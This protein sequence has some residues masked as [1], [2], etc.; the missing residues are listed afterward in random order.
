MKKGSGFFFYVL[1]NKLAI[2]FIVAILAIIGYALIPSIPKGVFPNVFFPRIEV[3]IDDGYTPIRQML[4]A[5]TKPAEDTLKTVQ[6]VTKV[7]S[8]TSV[9]SS[10][11][12]LYFNWN[13]NPYLAYQLVQARIAALKNRLPHGAKIS[14]MQATPSKYPVAI[15]AIGSNTL[16]RTQLTKMLYYDL[17]PL[18]LSVKGVYD[19]Q[20]KAP[21]WSE[22]E[23]LLNAQ[24]MRSYHLN[25]QTLLR[26]LKAQNAIAF[27][28]LVND[29]HKQYLLSLYQKHT[30]ASSLLNLQIPLTGS[31]SVA[32]GDLAVLVK[33]SAPSREFSAA[34]GFRNAVVFNLLRQP[35]ADALQVVERFN[36]KIK[37]LAP[38]LHKEGITLASYYDG[39][40]FTKEA[41]KSVRDAVI[42]G[43]LIAVGV[44][45]FFL[46]KT[47][48]SL[49][50]LVLIPLTFAITVIGMKLFG[51]D[52]N[53]F[54]LGG[55]AAALGGLID[56]MI[57]VIENIER[58]FQKGIS[59]HDAVVEGSKEIL[60]I[61]GIATLLATLIFIPLLLV[62]GIVGL[63]FK[64]LAFVLV[65]TYIISQIIAI[66]LT[67]II[68]FAALP[69]P[70]KKEDFLQPLI[71]RYKAFLHRAFGFAW[72][73]LPLL[74]LF[75]LLS[76]Y[77]FKS[78]PSTFLPKWDEGNI[79]MDFTL[80]PGISVA[81]SKREFL[82]AAA[83][84]NK[85]K[86][87]KDWT[88]RLGTSLGAVSNPA[89]IGDFL[90]TLKKERSESTFVVMHRLRSEILQAVPNLQDLG[91]SQ[92]LEDRLGDIMGAD[93]PIA[94]RLFGTH[95]IQLIQEGNKLKKKL[96]TLQGIEE[97]NVLTSYASPTI[98]IRLKND[99]EALYGIDTQMLATQIKTLYYGKLIGSIAKG[100]QLIDVR[101]LLSRP[102]ED[103]L[104]YLQD[105]LL[106]YSAKLHKNIPLHDVA[107]IRF[108]N[109]VPQITHYNLSP[110]C[111]LGVHFRGNDMS[112][113]VQEIR[114]TLQQASLPAGITA[115]IGGIYKQQQRSFKQMGFVILFALFILFTGLLLR[116][117]SFE[118]PF[119]IIIALIV[120]L[121]G[122][123]LA[124]KLTAKPLDIT[125]FM[126]MLI[127]LSI[128]I[129]NNV[130]IYDFYTKTADEDEKERIL[131]AVGMRIR[132]VLMTMLSNAFALLP[133]ALAIGSGTQIIQD[134]AIAVM[135]GLIFAIFINLF[136]TP[137][138]FYWLKTLHRQKN[139]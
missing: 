86:A 15:Y 3:T 89:N 21:R 81:Q 57:I 5:V 75:F 71:E 2:F 133:I 130:L 51:I 1:K 23:I 52:F 29:Y 10:T 20:I 108:E 79:V 118:I 132:P 129:N 54:S 53:I 6:D 40:R 58:H 73:S 117:S 90:V 131:S 59:K 48:L 101:V 41:I 93:A 27:A 94:V 8:S 13:I 109:R 122:V 49:A 110:V 84:L 72:I 69:T 120:T 7:V 25:I 125:A 112:M 77:L 61:M 139:I 64:Q 115:D 105:N 28:G 36:K 85:D 39:T 55:M 111:I 123:F 116:F 9:G 135:G 12:D 104:R 102:N 65:S 44:I 138:F 99:A 26:Q 63:F 18:F 68:A 136:L 70:Q 134:M 98:K 33:S 67:P 137:L 97:V 95:P 128:V 56:Q 124:L 16:S 35:N 76:G 42:L 50:S 113:I 96:R 74:V 82:R 83:V 32:L 126:G 88:M 4:F 66:F 106:L 47:K 127:V 114:Q 30:H 22:Y 17:K 46:R 107:D 34:S 92:V 62:S 60:P 14:I 37:E 45:F 103:P 11:V 80:P 24:K 38:K 43:A 87:A 121:G 91:L 31:R 119:T 100:E 19:I 78:I